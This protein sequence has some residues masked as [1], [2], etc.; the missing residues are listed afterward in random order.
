MSP[1]SPPLLENWLPTPARS[2]SH[3]R[4]KWRQMRLV[5]YLRSQLLCTCIGFHTCFESGDNACNLLILPIEGEKSR[6]NWT[7]LL[8]AWQCVGGREDQLPGC[9]QLNSVWERRWRKKGLLKL[10]RGEQIGQ[11]KPC[12]ILSLAFCRLA[13]SKICLKTG[14]WAFNI[15]W[16]DDRHFRIGRAGGCGHSSFWWWPFLQVPLL[17]IVKLGLCP[18]LLWERTKD[19]DCT[20]NFVLCLFLLKTP[21]YF[22]RFVGVALSLLC[23]EVSTKVAFFKST[24]KK[25]IFDASIF[26]ERQVH[27][28]PNLLSV[29]SLMGLTGK[30]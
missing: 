24:Q 12:G 3:C 25:C 17:C 23:G 18:W 7:G 22:S 29:P 5:Q 14:K 2:G 28:F 10:P 4:G 30:K 19:Q 8:C 11:H 26:L 16:E 1:P 27:R 6:Q 13:I 20:C 15:H 21:I 9:T